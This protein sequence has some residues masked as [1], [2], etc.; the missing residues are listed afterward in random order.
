M[1]KELKAERLKMKRKYTY[2]MF[3][4][5]FVFSAAWMF[6]A[7]SDLDFD[8]FNNVRALASIN[9]LMIASI[10][11][12][13]LVA[14]Y[15][16]RAADV[17]QYGSCYKWI[18]C[19]QSPVSIWNAKIVSGMGYI[20]LYSLAQTALLLGACLYLGETWDILYVYVFLDI[21]LTSTA[22]FFLQLWLSIRSE[23]QL[24][25]LFISIAGTFGGVFSWLLS[26]PLRYLIPW[27]YYSALCGIRMYYDE[28]ARYTYY[29]VQPFPWLWAAVL[30]LIILAEY[31]YCRKAF[32]GQILD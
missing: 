31:F 17:E 14:S 12:P 22:L 11:S 27:G 18:A 26:F 4:A 32:L 15:A 25:P 20:T 6:Y 30:L 1:R 3:L 2:L 5:C 21:F 23:S 16:S 19:L 10:I 28:A 8:K 9:T 29:S 24:V 13:I 7:I